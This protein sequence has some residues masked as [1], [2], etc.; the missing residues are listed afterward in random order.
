MSR[1]YVLNRTPVPITDVPQHFIDALVAQE[2]S[3]Y[4]KHDGVD[5]IGLARA[6]KENL[7][8]GQ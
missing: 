1:L 5:Y 6:V 2:D 8:A 3:R 7:S 4:F